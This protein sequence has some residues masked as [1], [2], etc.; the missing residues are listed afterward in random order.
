MY[1]CS[2]LLELYI[3]PFSSLPS[4]FISPFLSQ[5]SATELTRAELFRLFLFCDCTKSPSVL[6]FLNSDTDPYTSCTLYCFSIIVAVCM[7]TRGMCVCWLTHWIIHNIN[8]LDHTQHTHTGS[9]TTYTHWII[10]NIHTLNLCQNTAK[11]SSNS[12]PG[13]YT[14]FFTESHISC[15][16]FVQYVSQSCSVLHPFQYGYH[17]LL[18]EE[19]QTKQDENEW[20][21]LERLVRLKWQQCMKTLM[22]IGTDI[23][24][25]PAKN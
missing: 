20:E 1:I 21:R 5:V 13:V 23:Q 22:H 12:R 11:W 10:H 16:Y 19:P 7:R 6:S 14:F 2:L 24:L 3:F 8:T 9:Y 17:T 15:A 18:C 25:M 4:S